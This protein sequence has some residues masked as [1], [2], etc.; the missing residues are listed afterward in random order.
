MDTL[1]HVAIP[2]GDIAAAVDWYAERF[3]VDIAYA[4]DSWALL[5][6]E[7]I[8]LALVLPTQHPAHIAVERPDAAAYGTLT[9]HRDGTASVYLQDPWQNTVEILKRESGT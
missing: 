5:R 4:D 3:E 6:F 8:S 7:N 9:P 2:V 1:H